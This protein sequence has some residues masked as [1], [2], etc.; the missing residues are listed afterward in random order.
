MTYIGDNPS[1]G[2][3]PLT[4]FP[5]DD[6]AGIAE[7]QSAGLVGAETDTKTLRDWIFGKQANGDNRT[8]LMAEPLHSSPQAISYAPP[9]FNDDGTVKTPALSKLFFGAND[10]LLRMINAESGQEEWAFLPQEL[11]GIQADLMKNANDFTGESHIYGIDGTPVFLD[12]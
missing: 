7:L 3:V 9:E 5:S 1:N 2:A 11:F 4:E 8:W 6:D 10:G 12:K